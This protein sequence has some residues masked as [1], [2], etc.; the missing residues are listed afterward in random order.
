MNGSVCIDTRPDHD[1]SDRQ[2]TVEVR[3]G[4]VSRRQAE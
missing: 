2:T 4:G 3:A 1:P